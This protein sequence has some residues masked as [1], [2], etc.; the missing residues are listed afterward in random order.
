MVVNNP[1]LRPYFLGGRW[2]R[3]GNLVTLNMTLVRGWNSFAIHSVDAL[4]ALQKSMVSTPC[5]LVRIIVSAWP[6]RLGES[7]NWA[8]LSWS[9]YSLNAPLSLVGLYI[10]IYPTKSLTFSRGPK[11][12]HVKMS[13]SKIDDDD[14]DDDD[15]HNEEEEAE[16]VLSEVVYE[17]FGYW[18]RKYSTN[19][20]W[21]KCPPFLQKRCHC[22]LASHLW[23]PLRQYCWWFRNPIPNHLLDVFQT[24]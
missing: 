4:D 15:D 12:C 19:R 6:Q 14:V 7:G 24:L 10:Y 1:L 18:V 2:H 22:H 20:F 8:H 21:C 5:R 11:G 3:G 23:P 9:P 13:L 17:L 16:L